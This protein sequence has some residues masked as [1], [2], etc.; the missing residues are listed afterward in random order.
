[1]NERNRPNAPG[2]AGKRPHNSPLDNR[3]SSN[4]NPSRSAKRLLD[5]VI[6]S[7]RPRYSER[8]PRQVA[9]EE[10]G[11][12][13]LHKYLARCGVASRRAAEI[14]ISEGRVTVNGE[15]IMEMGFKVD[16]ERDQIKVDGGTIKP[17]SPA[18]VLLNKPKG[19]LTTLSDPRRRPTV[20]QYLP[21]LGVM[22]RPVGRLDMESEGLLICTN[23]GNLADRLTHPSF[24]VEKEYDVIVRGDLSDKSLKRL[25]EGVFIMGKWTAEAYVEKISYERRSDTTKL[26]MIIHEGRNRQIRLMCES[27]GHPVEDLKRVRIGPLTIRG[28]RSGEARII[29]VVE[30]EELWKVSG[31][32]AK[33]KWLED[34]FE[35]RSPQR[36]RV[37]MTQ[38]PLGEGEELPAAESLIRERERQR[39][40]AIRE[41]GE[42]I[43]GDSTGR[44]Y[45]DRPRRDS[46]DRKPYGDRPQRGHGDRPYQDRRPQGDRPYQDRRPQGDRPYQD[47]RPQGDRPYQDRRPQGDRPYQD[48]RP[49]GDRPYQDRKPQGDRPWQDRK[50]NQDRKPQG[51]RPWQDRKPSSGYQGKPQGDRK[52]GGFKGK[53]SYDRN[54]KPGGYGN[55]KRTYGK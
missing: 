47:R 43:Q 14:I 30:R 26:R 16:P 17:E 11:E 55:P 7:D 29:S 41:Q 20:V 4:Y 6:E 24:G 33:D 51:D 35:S 1:M 44:S 3:R 27:V 52:P 46:V 21:D 31:P 25:R 39:Q 45:E 49:Q 10:A 2:G 42:T 37:R 34:R 36:D 23:D 19:V 13:R 15:L 38:K 28:L 22:L 50:P 12:E 8:A 5:E 48:R 9:H 54:K 32:R 40:E 53:P 18:Y